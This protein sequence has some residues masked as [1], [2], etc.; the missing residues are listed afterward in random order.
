MLVINMMSHKEI[1][2]FLLP[3]YTDVRWFHEIVLQKANEIRFIKGRL[4][5]GNHFNSAPFANMLVIFKEL[6]K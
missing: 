2:V 6:S 3:A 5:F 1:A 4:K